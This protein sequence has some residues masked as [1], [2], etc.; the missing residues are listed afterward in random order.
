MQYRY[1]G[2]QPAEDPGGELVHP[3]DIREFEAEPD[4]P[5][6][7]RAGPDPDVPPPPV[8]PVAA[9]AKTAPDGAEGGM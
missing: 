4:C 3:G 6:W 9:P 5:P 1:A 8:T 2:S 7:E